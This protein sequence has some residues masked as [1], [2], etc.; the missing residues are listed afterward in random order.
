MADRLIVRGAR[1]HNLKDVSLDLPRDALIVFTGL[2]GSGQ[3]QPRLR[4]D[5]RRGPAPVRRVA[6]GVRA[7][8]PRPDGQARRRLHR[9]P[10]ARRSRST[11]SPPPATRARPSGR[12]PRSTTTCGCCTPAPAGRTARCAG[13]RSAGRRRSRSSTGSSSCAEG[14]RFQV[15]A[16]VV[17]GRKGEYAELFRE[18][19]TKGYSRVRVDGVVH[20]LTEPPTLK[21][22]EKHTIEVVVD[23]LAVKAVGQA[24]PHRLGRDRAGAGRRAGHPRVRRPARGRP[25]PRAAVL[26][27]P[28]LPLRRPVVRG[29]RAAVVLVQ[30]PVRRLPG[31]HRARHPD[32]GRPG[33]GRPRP[34][35][36]RWPRARSRRGRPGRPASTSRRLLVALVRGGRVPD[37]HA[38]GAAAGAGAG[39]RSC[40]GTTTRS[41]SATRNRYG[42]ER[43]Y[44]TRFEGVVPFVQRRHAEAESDASRERFEGY[45][46]EVPCPGLQGRPA[47]AGVPR[48]DP[49]R[50]VDLRHRRDADRRVRA[51][52]CAPST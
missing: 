18:L 2:S 26:R 34:R 25:A 20:P 1:E 39:R 11:R 17:R 27:A 35:P 52:S 40:T 28:R 47:E 44:Y 6:V 12:S 21:K 49:R 50:P 15:L 46:R 24:A 32:G 10:V 5:L 51:I 7:P 41:T 14:T 4:H 29:A 36:D 23:R 16:P 43:S 19:Q 42:R 8:V 3:V 45:M 13:G 31:V 9:G 48:G 30:L 38:L 37:G 22:Q 33:A